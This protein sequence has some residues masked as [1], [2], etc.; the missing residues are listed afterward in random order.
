MSVTNPTQSRTLWMGEI[1][2]W[3]DEGYVKCLFNNYGIY[4]TF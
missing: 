1:D 3:M 4:R 2:H